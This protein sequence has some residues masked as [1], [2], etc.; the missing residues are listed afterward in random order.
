VTISSWLNF[1]RPAP[2]GRGL[3]RGEI[4]GSA[5]LQPA[6]SV[7]VSSERFF[8]V[9]VCFG[10]YRGWMLLLEMQVSNL[11]DS[12]WRTHM[13]TVNLSETLTNNATK[14]WL[15]TSNKRFTFS[16]S[17]NTNNGIIIIVIVVAVVVV[18]VNVEDDDIKIL[19]CCPTGSRLFVRGWNTWRAGAQTSCGYFWTW[20][21]RKWTSATSGTTSCVAMTRYRHCPSDASTRPLHTSSSSFIQIMFRPTTPAFEASLTSSTEVGRISDILCVSKILGPLYTYWKPRHFSL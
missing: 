17:N 9:G 16:N 14:K 2:P 18:N 7:C 19:N 21:G 11:L 10:D 8:P 5:L 4:F 13:L 3:R 6:R 15:N 20:R 12:A 1:G